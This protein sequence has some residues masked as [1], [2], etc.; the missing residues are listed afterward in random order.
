MIEP[1]AP[2][3]KGCTKLSPVNLLGRPHSFESKSHWKQS[4]PFTERTAVYQEG[5]T[6]GKLNTF[7]DLPI[8]EIWS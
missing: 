6:E 3:Q 4:I 2:H 5:T 8:G 1:S 7:E